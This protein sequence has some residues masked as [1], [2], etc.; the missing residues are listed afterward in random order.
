MKEFLNDCLSG[1]VYL[2][3]QEIPTDQ[4]QNQIFE[5]I[6]ASMLKV[7]NEAQPEGEVV[8]GS[9]Q[10]PLNQSVRALKDN[11]LDT[12]ASMSIGKD[13]VNSTVAHLKSLSEKI[14]PNSKEVTEFLSEL[15]EG[16]KNSK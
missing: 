14:A 9:L 11:F 8:K 16:L 6:E 7:T 10:S 1:L 13:V 12:R 4:L 3:G 5:I 2:K 15:L